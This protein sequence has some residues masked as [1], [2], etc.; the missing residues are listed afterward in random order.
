MAYQGNQPINIDPNFFVPPGV[1]D[2][3]QA[4]KENGEFFYAP[5]DVA[6]AG[7]AP[8]LDIPQATIP[9]PPTSYEIVA[10]HVRHS[11]DGS[12]VVDVTIEFPE[13]PGV[14]SIDV[15]ITKV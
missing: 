2:A 13:I 11:P 12:T 8:I 15:R 1:V 6:S 4:N 5:G 9:M 7:D 14:A 3:R 10:Q